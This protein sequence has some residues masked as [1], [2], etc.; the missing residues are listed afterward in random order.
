MSA[1]QSPEPG[2]GSASEPASAS[3]SVAA[4]APASGS[5]PT[6]LTKL[7][8]PEPGTA[9]P[10]SPR[11][12][13]LLPRRRGVRWLLGAAVVV[14]LGAVAVGAGA[15]LERHHD[16]SVPVFDR[17]HAGWGPVRAP[18]VPE[19]PDGVGKLVIRGEDGSVEVVPGDGALPPGVSVGQGA[20]PG[21]GKLAPAALPAVPADQALA[22]ALAAVPD[23]KAAALAVVGREG[24]GSSWSVEVL[25]ADGVRHLVTVDGTDGSVTGNTVAAGR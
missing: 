24:G 19:L 14:V 5:E 20:G 2:A 9:A 17:A 10:A 23:G 11:P 15:A 8:P 12:R 18:G 22:K 4:P 21:D 6:D 1:P 13:R 3:E 25:G 7:A 16:R